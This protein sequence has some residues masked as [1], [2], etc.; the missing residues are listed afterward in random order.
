MFQLRLGLNVYSQKD[1]YVFIPRGMPGKVKVSDDPLNG[2][3]VHVLLD[4]KAALR[5]FTVAQAKECSWT[6]ERL[7]PS[8]SQI[9]LSAQ[10]PQYVICRKLFEIT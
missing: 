5:N 7:D 8:S 10:M 3:L 9:F 4:A 1:H 6:T 2:G